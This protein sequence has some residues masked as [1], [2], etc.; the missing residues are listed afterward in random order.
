MKH[1][2]MFSSGIGSWAAAIRFAAAHG[3]D[4]LTLLFADTLIEDEDNYRFIEE[5]AANVGG[6]LVKVCDGRDPWQVFKDVRWLGN[7]RIAQCSHLLKQKPCRQWLINFDPSHEAIVH[8][9][10]DWSEI[11]RLPAIQKHWQPW[12]TEAP[13]TTPPYLDKLQLLQWA[14]L[15]G[16]KSPRLY[17]YHFLHSNCG[18]FCVRAGQAHFA[19]LLK[20]FPERYHY[21]EQKEE[22]LREYLGKNVAILRSKIDGVDY[23]LTLRELRKRIEARPV[24]LDLLDWGGCGCFV[25][26]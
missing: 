14:E 20:H 25:N 5:A 19:N 17:S 23:P 7:S 15:E 22:D 1:V 26:S 16:L 18:G 10:I 3:T 4:N 2:V 8:V 13:L 21:H 12:Q 9:G 24:P 11:H 6:N